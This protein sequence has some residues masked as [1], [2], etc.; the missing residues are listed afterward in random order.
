MRFHLTFLILFK[1]LNINAQTSILSNGEWVKIGVVQSGVYKLDK[2][3]FDNHNIS[4]EGVSPDKIK[5]FGSGYN[6]ALSQ[7]NS[8]S[9]IISPNEIQSIFNGNSDS[10]FDDNQ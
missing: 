2:N 1:I 9:N 5:I 4:L 10:M 3:F 7:L 6:G 8:L